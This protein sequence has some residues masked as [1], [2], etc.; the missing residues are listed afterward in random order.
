MDQG[1]VAD[2]LPGRDGNEVKS[3]LQSHK[4]IQT[5]CRDRSGAYSAAVNEVIPSASQVAD[6]F[7]LIKNLSDSVYQL[8]KAEYAHL[9]R[10]LKSRAVQSDVESATETETRDVPSKTNE[11]P[12]S[13]KGAPSDYR[14]N[15]LMKLN[16]LL[17][18]GLVLK[19]SPE[20]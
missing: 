17:I 6:R 8:I 12:T 10:P 4:E 5:V 15:C 7:H 11:S 14:K 20:G 18:R 19:R 3:F 13:I 16:L 2:I 9:V 1:R